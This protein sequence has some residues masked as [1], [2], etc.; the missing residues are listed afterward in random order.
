FRQYTLAVRD[1]ETGRTLPDRV[2][3]TDSFAWAADNR[4]FFY[5]VEDAAK[6]RYRLYRHTLGAPKDALV[7]EEKDERFELQAE[8]SRSRVY[9]FVSSVSQ[10]T[11]EVRYLRAD[12]PEESLRVVAAREPEH[13]YQVEHHGDRF[14]IRTNSGG[15]NFRLVWAPAADPRRE[16]WKEVLPHRP[17]V[18]LEGMDFFARHSVLLEREEGLPRL[19]ITDLRSGE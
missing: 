11:S 10:T 6:R 8:R 1:L 7:Y 18:M 3:K 4:T 19:R 9:I 2:E 16:N 17:S 14:Y 5:T 13:E 15:R 12:R